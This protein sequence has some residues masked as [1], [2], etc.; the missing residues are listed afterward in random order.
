MPPPS[1]YREYAKMTSVRYVDFDQP[2]EHGVKVK[3][4]TQPAPPRV[5]MEVGH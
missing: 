1:G 5:A 3:V 4:H 2:S